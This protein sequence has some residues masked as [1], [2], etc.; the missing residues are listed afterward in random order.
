MGKFM[1]QEYK[2]LYFGIL[3]L[4]SYLFIHFFF[5]LFQQFPRRLQQLWEMLDLPGLFQFSIEVKN[6]E[7]V[8]TLLSDAFVSTL[9]DFFSYLMEV[10]PLHFSFNS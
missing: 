10:E 2:S 6:E 4:H 5:L 1:E 7:R 3:K 9:V 8:V